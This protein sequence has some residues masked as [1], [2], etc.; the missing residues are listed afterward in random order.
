M[1]P[2]DRSLHGAR[3]AAGPTAARADARDDPALLDLAALEEQARGVLPPAV[4]D[5]YAGGAEAEITLGEATAGL[6]VVAA[7]APGA[8]RRSRRCGWPRP[9]SA[10]RWR[11]PIGVAPWAYQS[12]AHPDGERGSARGAAAAGALMTVST[13]AS[14]AAGRRRRPSSRRAEVVPALPRCTPPPTPT[15]SPAGAGR[16]GYR[17]LVLTVDLPRARTPAAR[18]GQ[19]RSRCPPTCRWAT[20]PAGT[21]RRRVPGLDL[22]RH[23]PVRRAVRPPGRGQGRAPRG[24]RRAVRAAPGRPRSGSPRTAA[25]RPTRSSPARPRC[26]RSSTPSATRSRSTPTAGSAPDRT[27]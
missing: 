16:A 4:A 20:A 14:T 9:C 21:P 8:A 3:P 23:R 18:R 11:T 26:P 6:A 10:A 5:Y 7:A 12:M 22:R 13:S 1:A 24:R 25:G 27:C 2:A 17:A 19:R 15:T